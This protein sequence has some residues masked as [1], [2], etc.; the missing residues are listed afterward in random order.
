MRLCPSTNGRN[1]PL[2]APCAS[3]RHPDLVTGVTAH[4]EYPA[5]EDQILA[6]DTQQHAFHPRLLLQ[7]ERH[8]PLRVLALPFVAVAVW[9]SVLTAGA[10]FFDWTA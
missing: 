2:P 6:F 9:F 5:I 1:P 7:I 8:H 3:N 10:H 4:V